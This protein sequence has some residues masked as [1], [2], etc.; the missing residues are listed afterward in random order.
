MLRTIECMNKKLFHARLQLL[1]CVA[2]GGAMMW[3]VVVFIGLSC[4]CRAKNG[5]SV[6]VEESM[7][8]M[9]WPVDWGGVTWG[10]V[11]IAPSNLYKVN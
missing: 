8:A 9:T 4:R 7:R 2:S 3:G 1:C 5:I 10:Y 11:L 6:G